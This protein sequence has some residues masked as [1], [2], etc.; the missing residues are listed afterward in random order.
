M[1]RSRPDR[2]VRPP[3]SIRP[4]GFAREITARGARTELGLLQE[5]AAA[6][7]GVDVRHV[8][9]LQDRRGERGGGFT[10]RNA[11]RAQLLA[12]IAR[13]LGLTEGELL[14]PWRVQAPSPGH[15]L[16]PARRF[17]GRASERAALARWLAD[18]ADPA[19]VFALV[20]RGGEGKTALVAATLPP[21]VALRVWSFYEQPDVGAMLNALC[22]SEI[23]RT[24]D[25][26]AAALDALARAPTKVLVL[27]GM[28]MLQSDGDEAR[29]RGELTD[30][31]LR[32]FLRAV[33]ATR[34]GARVLLTS[35]HPVTD[36]AA[37]EQNGARTLDLGPLAVDDG[38]ALLRRAG[39][40][41]AAGVLQAAV[42]EHGAHALSLTVL[43]AARPGLALL[44]AGV[45]DD[46]DELRRDDPQARRLATLL[47]R[48]T[49]RLDDVD[50]DLLARVAVFPRG[51]PVDLLASLA[52]QGGALAGALAGL[53]AHRIV[54][55]LDRLAARG[56][57]FAQR[58]TARYS[59]HPFVRDALRARAPAR[60]VHAFAQAQTRARLDARP[61][62]HGAER[63][64]DLTTLVEHALGAGAV[65]D[66][67]SI[68]L[69]TL[70]G[71]ARLGILD[72]E[73]AAGLRLARMFSP[74]G[75][76]AALHPALSPGQAEAVAYEWGLFASALGDLA[77][78]RRAMTH[79]L[80]LSID[81]HDLAAAAVVHRGLAY[82]AH[83]AGDLA[84]AQRAAE[85]AVE[86]ASR[87]NDRH[88]E[89]RAW[90]LRAMVLHA[91]GRHDEAGA[92]FA[93]ADACGDRPAARRALWRA[94]WQLDRGEVQAARALAATA[95]DALAAQAWGGHAAEARCVVGAAAL[96]AGALDDA[97][98]A[99]AA[100]HAVAVRTGEVELLL[101]AHALG[102]RV[103]DAAGERAARDALDAEARA[104][105]EVHG[106]A[107][108]PP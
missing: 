107:A 1:S 57:V 101:R 86:G 60:D 32:R 73:F 76:P 81:R 52:A 7:A 40:R 91:A 64:D 79:A 53:P 8:A 71:F 12:R 92:A 103:L 70:G 43:A 83:L 82:T 15:V 35:R 69:R 47:E 89:G 72:G 98:A 50:R 19:R 80:T 28:E 104:L 48:V 78:G 25:P 42:A 62:V 33:A 38:V 16:Q 14:V 31:S 87:A 84:T 21:E 45:N 100:A 3:S 29:S 39:V 93:R 36:L 97:R 67:A 94:R 23:E 46:L 54:R 27:D 61:G 85:A 75:D 102:I 49:A 59:A 108:L 55:R 13:E 17:V 74:C 56:V 37:W 5:Q 24:R 63:L 9:S 11:S 90:S 95:H 18:P 106:F 30:P 99:W 68:F 44:R 58:P 77:T 88:G 105:R 6:A 22:G 26:V 41:G 34:T 51:A 4:A 96:S 65:R 2:R 10:V 20:A 66:A